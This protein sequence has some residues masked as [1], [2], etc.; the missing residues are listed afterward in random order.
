MD[1]A[2]RADGDAVFPVRNPLYIIELSHNTKEGTSD[3]FA[4]SYWMEW[5]TI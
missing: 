4:A 3:V 2:D 5:E 1:G